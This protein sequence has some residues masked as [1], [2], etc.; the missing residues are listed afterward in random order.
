MTAALWGGLLLQV[1]VLAAALSACA[2]FVVALRARAGRAARARR[3]GVVAVLATAGLAAAAFVVLEWMLVAR[4]TS[5]GFVVKTT[6]AAM[7]LYYRVTALWSAMEGS[8]LLWVLVLAAV[9]ALFAA[10]RVRAG[11]D[12]GADDRAVAATTDATADPAS[13]VRAWGWARVVA[14]GSVAAF[15]AVS[16]LVTPF[17]AVPEITEGRPSPLLQDHPAMGVHPPLLYAGFAAYLVPYA[18][19]IGALLAPRAVAGQAGR[20]WRGQVHRWSLVAWIL[21]A[22]GI[23]L[24]AW[25]SYAVLGWGGYWVWDPVENASALPLLAGTALLH[26]VGTRTRDPGWRRW[27]VVLAGLPFALVL[28]A[29]FLTRSGLVASIHAFALSPVGLW[30][31]GIALAATVLWGVLAAT[32][33]RR[34]PAAP[35]AAAGRRGAWGVVRAG[36]IALLLVAAVVLVGTVLPT[37]VQAVAGDVISVGPPWY[38]RTLAPLAVAILALMAIGPVL[39]ER[40]RSPALLAAAS[41]TAALAGA[42]A[43]VFLR[44]AGL[45]IAIAAAAFI[46]VTLAERAVRRPRRRVTIGA[47]IAHAGIAFSAV[48]IVASGT[49]SIS[50]QS[51]AVGQVASFGPVDATLVSFDREDEGQTTTSTARILIADDDELLIDARP[52]LRYFPEHATVVAGP[53]IRSQPLSDIYVSMLDLDPEAGVAT[54]RIAVIPMVPWLWWTGALT[55]AGAALCLPFRRAGARG[56]EAAS[57]PALLAREGAP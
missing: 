48:A 49:A 42:I 33:T 5:A 39:R 41:A 54:V 36:R 30:L 47:L 18:L 17:Y 8:L 23:G 44:D 40:D 6:E 53:D 7:P 1:L 14:A 45:V 26:A 51:L 31:G 55:V 3:V 20:R 25:W 9:A 4:D 21:L 57:E 13:G 27:A 2:A 28:L 10:R 11:G 24:G 52:Q 50:Q 38:G 19:S 22:L 37:I 12:V 29:T 43:A 46:L 15:A 35:P 56:T 34:L 16:L 32:R